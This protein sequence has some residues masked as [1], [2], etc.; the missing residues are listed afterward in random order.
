MDKFLIKKKP[1]EKIENKGK[2]NKEKGHSKKL[3]LGYIKIKNFVFKE[4]PLCKYGA[5]CYRKNAEHLKQFRHS[6][7]ETESEKVAETSTDVSKPKRARSSPA[8]AEACEGIKKNTIFIFI[9]LL[10]LN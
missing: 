6:D 2:E 5:K 8:K 7:N 4:L 10:V 1:D 9:S 3:R